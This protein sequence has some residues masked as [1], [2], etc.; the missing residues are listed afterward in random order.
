MTL[1]AKGLV[2]TG[3]P[4]LDEV[5]NGGLPGRRLYLIQGQPGAGKT[6]LALRFLIAGAAAGER[7]LYVTLSETREELE[8]VVT[9]HGWS[10]DGVEVYEMSAADL[11]PPEREENTLYVPAEVE[12]GERISALLEEV[13]RVKPTRV[14]LDSCS[15]LRLLA[16][17]PLRFRRQLL[18]LK[19]HLVRR[20]CTVLLLEN[21][22]AVDGDPM[23]QS[24]VHG[25]IVLEQLTSL[26]GADRR[27]M[28]VVKVRELAYRRGYHDMVIS[29]GG[30]EIFPRLVASEHRRPFVPDL[31]ASGVRELDSLLGGGLDRGTSMLIVGPTGSGKS[32]LATQYAVAAA[33]RGERA[34]YFTFDEGLE[35]LFGRAEKLGMR[36]EEHV[37]QRRV[38]VKQ[39]DPAELSPGEFI[40]EVRK[41]VV[42]DGVQLVVIDSLNGFMHAMPEEHFLTT[43]LHEL[44][45]FL[46]QQGV[47]TLLVM[48]QHGFVGDVV[49]PLEVSYLADTVLLT[50]Y[51]EANGR[52]R[53]A[54][55]VLKKRA[56]RHEDTIRELAVIEG[57]GVVVGQPLSDFRG[58]L[59]GAPEYHGRPASALLNK[60]GPTP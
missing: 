45:S 54:L 50:R 59:T 38:Q 57:K 40:S 34:A 39:V 10:L 20:N 41:A 46:R 60:G 47:T 36:L 55:S 22:N 13:D 25:V 7:A 29:R 31:C 35:T 26:Y 44:L 43:Q 51:F 56:G 12:L 28:H 8:A 23:L 19:E 1:A 14:V 9:G 24:L 18:A 30:V 37:E 3:T 2:S 32:T 53:K 15:E 49:G 5:L 52:L 17:S 27:R 11:T 42:K 16:Q 6:T 58:V 21:P 33:A 48:A 4:G